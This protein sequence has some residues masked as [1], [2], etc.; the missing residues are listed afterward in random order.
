MSPL[1][2]EDAA[3]VE[4]PEITVTTTDNSNHDEPSDGTAHDGAQ[5]SAEELPSDA[6]EE[7]RLKM[8]TTGTRAQDDLERDIGRQA[9][10]M[11]TEQ[12]DARDKKRI[13]KLEAEAK[14]A[15]AAI[16]KLKNR[17][18]LPALDT[19]KAKLRGEI[20]AYRDKIDNLATS[21]GMCL[22]DKKPMPF[23]AFW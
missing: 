20:A 4:T 23:G 11:M 17:L 2:S 8:L 15:E 18:A 6:D 9:D 5:D 12:A 14:R 1:P 22:L 13:E 16:Q 7:A 3:P 19:Q 10:Q 21:E